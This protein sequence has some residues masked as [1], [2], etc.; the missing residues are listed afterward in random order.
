MWCES[1]EEE[2]KGKDEANRVLAFYIFSGKV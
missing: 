1:C 2:G